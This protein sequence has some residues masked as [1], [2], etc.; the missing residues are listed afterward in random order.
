[1]FL[2]PFYENILFGWVDNEVLHE[3]TWNRTS[4]CQILRPSHEKNWRETDYREALTDS[5]RN[6][7]SLR[8]IQA[9]QTFVELTTSHLKC[10]TWTDINFKKQSRKL[11]SDFEKLFEWIWS[12]QRPGTFHTVLG[13]FS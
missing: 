11:P 12:K 10:R 5:W 4:M 8:I 2:R 7:L 6:Q 1:M 3:L 9:N 13:G